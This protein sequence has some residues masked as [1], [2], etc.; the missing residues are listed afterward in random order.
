MRFVPP[1]ENIRRHHLEDL[2]SQIGPIRKSS[3]IVPRSSSSHSKHSNP[4]EETEAEN[5]APASYGFIKYTS[6]SDAKTAASK[7]DKK[8]L[9]LSSTEVIQLRVECASEAAQKKAKQSTEGRSA[10]KSP[11]S[12]ATA[13]EDDNEPRTPK[14]P[15]KAHRL[16]LRNLSFYAKESH[17]RKALETQFGKVAEVHIPQVPNTTAA[18]PHASTHRGFCFVTF[19]NSQDAQKCL[20][21]AQKDKSSIA[22]R[23]RPVTV[24]LA[25]NKTDYESRK[26]QQKAP[27]RPDGSQAESDKQDIDDDDDISTNS[28]ESDDGSSS[29]SSDS[30][31]EDEESNDENEDESALSDEEKE[32][33]KSQDRDE[34][35]VA[36]RRALF[37]RNLPFDSTRHDLFE[38]FRQF[39]R[40]TGIFLVK[41]RDT[42]IPK[43]TAFVSFRDQKAVAKALEAA[44]GDEKFVSQREATENPL[45][46][47]GTGTELS[48]RGRRIF[49]NAALDKS[50]AKTLVMEKTSDQ[51]TSGKDRRNLYLQ[52]EGR[53]DNDEEKN[54]SAWDELPE[55]D[56]NKRQ[57]A[58]SEKNTKL[59]SPIFFINPTRLSIRNISKQ[60]D[61]QDFKKLCVEATQRGLER[62]LVSVEDMIAHW[63]ASGEMTTRDIMSKVESEG[64]SIISSFDEKNVKRFIPSVFID[65]DFSGTKRTD[66][67]S[68]GFGFVEFE[69]HAHAL[70]CLR[71]LNNNMRYSE[72]FV[73]GGR[74]ALELRKKSKKRKKTKEVTENEFVGEDGMVRVPRLIVEFTVENKA[75]ARQQ[76][77]HRAQ[78]QANRIKQK[79]EHKDKTKGEA[80]K[81]RKK[82][83]GQRQRERKRKGLDNPEEQKASKKTQATVTEKSAEA[84]ENIETRAPKPKAVKPKKKK[85]KIDAE[86]AHFEKLVS[87]Y[88]DTLEDDAASE[89]AAQTKIQKRPKKRWF[90]E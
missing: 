32:K 56:R 80:K 48:I 43:G 67:P 76:A 68:R 30:E 16:I 28:Q 13:A 33:P 66:A 5:K 74:H 88:E 3:V 64:D 19:A 57:R 23:D 21:Q 58:W 44:R 14:S 60:V 90:E 78:Q 24:A 11:S 51:N 49:I 17:V 47:A 61:E 71:E 53:V 25:M 83:R 50:T 52:G 79:I 10:H 15:S 86:D 70:A 6:A 82:S 62:K 36:E 77:E 18:S 34:T 1:S 85:Q 9:R 39:G 8:S 65:R 2:F 42:N 84:E 46:N 37:V 12:A 69:H 26:Q 7:L 40:I 81:E 63:R 29:S 72:Q 73:Q 35:A 59:R 38:L 27:E 89:N 54:V 55:Q 75:K 87:K 31:D 45:Q 4:Y 20:E 22:I 41:D